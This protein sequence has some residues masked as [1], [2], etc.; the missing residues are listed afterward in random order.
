MKARSSK[1]RVDLLQI[2]AD[3]HRISPEAL[4]A[5]NAIRDVLERQRSVTGQH[6]GDRVD[7]SLRPDAASLRALEVSRQAAST[8]ER[9]TRAVGP[10]DARIIRRVLGDGLSFEELA[11]AEGKAGARAVGYLAARF[12]DGLEEIGRAY[13]AV[14]KASPLP[15]D[16]HNIA[17][18]RREIV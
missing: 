7:S 16:K 6:W 2:E 11:V 3:H 4:K 17:A 8:M 10:I 13:V 15:V 18:D 1:R 14:G 12:R 9:V 5:G